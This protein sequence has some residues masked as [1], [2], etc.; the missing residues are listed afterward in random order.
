MEIKQLASH[1]TGEMYIG[2]INSNGDELAQLATNLN[3]NQLQCFKTL[4]DEIMKKSNYSL[5]SMVAISEGSNFKLSKKDTEELI[6][7][8]IMDHWLS[9]E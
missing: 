9:M 6:D 4:V 8:L 2:L 5:S 3:P 7:L 1:E